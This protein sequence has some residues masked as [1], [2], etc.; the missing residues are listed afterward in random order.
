[1]ARSD[2]LVDVVSSWAKEREPGGL[3]R[4]EVDVKVNTPPLADGLDGALVWM[5]VA[6]NLLAVDFWLGDWD[7]SVSTPV[8]VVVGIATGFAGVESPG[9]GNAD[10]PR[11]S[12][13]E[14]RLLVDPELAEPGDAW[15]SGA[16]VPGVGTGGG[17]VIAVVRTGVEILDFRVGLGLGCNA[18]EV[19]VLS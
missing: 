1:L 11:I 10:L 3:V 4:G 2:G 15:R 6:E 5:I 12:S 13:L 17:M 19:P 8:A 14:L 16:L 9:G 7:A 18:W